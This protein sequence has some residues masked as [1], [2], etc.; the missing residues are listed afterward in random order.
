MIEKFFEL[1]AS[2]SNYILKQTISKHIAIN[3]KA[4]LV[5]IINHIIHSV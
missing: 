5:I 1:P 3:E 2:Y 4:N